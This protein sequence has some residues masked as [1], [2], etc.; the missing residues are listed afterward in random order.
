MD[1]TLLQNH[2]GDIVA[3]HSEYWSR[4][5]FDN[6]TAARDSGVNLAFF[7]GDNITWRIR[8]ENA[9][10]NPNPAPNRILVAYKSATADPVKDPRL[11]TIEWGAEK[12]P[13]IGN[14]GWGGAC[15]APCYYPLRVA[16]AASW[17][18]AGT[19]AK[20]GTLI[21]NVVGYEWD[22]S[23]PPA[24]VVANSS[25]HQQESTL[26]QAQSGAW[27]FDGGTI[28]WSWGLDSWGGHADVSTSL[29]QRVTQN[30]LNHFVGSFTL[31]RK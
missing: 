3:G 7:S 4:G 1:P 5:M 10:G 8:Y 13:L 24:T 15:H 23:A 31:L 25:G 26:Y 17:I 21:G 16:N 9:A 27:V 19:Q 20:N 11:A 12:T 22:N 28:Q 6:V 29:A 18:Y 30:I 2:Q 14:G